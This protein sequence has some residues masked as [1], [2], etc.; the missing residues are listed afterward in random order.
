MGEHGVRNN[1]SRWLDLKRGESMLPSAMS[2]GVAVGCVA[3]RRARRWRHD[4]REAPEDGCVNR[5]T[6]VSAVES[7]SFFFL[8]CGPSEVRNFAFRYSCLFAKKNGGRRSR[9]T[10]SEK[11]L[12]APGQDLVG[13]SGAACRETRTRLLADDGAPPTSSREGVRT[14]ARYHGA[15]TAMYMVST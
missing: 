13:A 3:C 1:V 10:E 5:A 12:L 14:G 6:I 11:Q 7:G 15:W 2:E 9:E 8:I 4:T